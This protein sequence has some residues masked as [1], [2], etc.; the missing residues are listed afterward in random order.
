MYTTTTSK[1]LAVGAATIMLATM[2]VF[3]TSNTNAQL[4]GPANTA[5]TSHG[6]LTINTALVQTS[7]LNAVLRTNGLIPTGGSGGAFGYGIITSAGL[8]AVIV[9]TTHQGYGIV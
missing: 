2:G 3:T 1:I 5:L 7:G 4:I 6:Y 8:S 9:T